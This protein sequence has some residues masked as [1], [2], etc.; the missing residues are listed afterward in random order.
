MDL[1]NLTYISHQHMIMLGNLPVN[2]NGQL[3]LMTT[4]GT[5][6]INLNVQPNEGPGSLAG[7]VITELTPI[8]MINKRLW[9]TNRSGKQT[10]AK[11]TR[12]H[13]REHCALAY[14]HDLNCQPHGRE[15]KP[16]ATPKLGKSG[17]SEV[18]TGNASLSMSKTRI[19]QL[20]Y[21]CATW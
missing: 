9:S 6:S 21:S 1:K 14:T 20:T 12:G 3:S 11:D 7:R 18:L 8:I 2:T 19:G 10:I 16:N 4:N 5:T 15:S 13:L 17:L